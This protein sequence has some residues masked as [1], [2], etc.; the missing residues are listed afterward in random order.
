MKKLFGVLL[1]VFLLSAL[2][3]GAYAKETIVYYLWDD[4][5]YNNIVEVFN[6]SQDEIFVDAKVI[7]AG[8]YQTKL[9][10]LLA[11]GEYMDAYMNKDAV[12]IF[13]MVDN[14][15]A[16]PVDAFIEKH[17]FDA[18]PLMAYKDA[19]MIDGEIYA[20]PFRGEAWFTYY[21]KKV[22][23]AAGVPTPET[24]VEKGEWTWDKFAEVAN[25]LA[26]GDGMVYGGLM[27]VWTGCHYMPA[28]QRG[29]K[30][31]TADGAIDIDDSI[32]YSLKLRKDLE[33]ARTIIPMAELLATKTHYS[34]AFWEGNLGMLIIGAW[35]PGQMLS[36]RDEGN[37]KG[38]TWDDWAL[39][40]LPCNESE[41]RTTGTPTSNVLHADSEKKDAAF[42]FLA[43]M[44]GPEGSAVV[45]KNGFMPAS[46][47]PEVLE[48]LK[49]VL[50]DESSIKYFTEPKVNVTG[51]FNKYGARVGTF[52]SDLVEEY[53]A[54]EMTGDQ[55]MAKV[56]A[57]FEEIL[58]S[59]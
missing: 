8:D 7:P 12:H 1:V 48:A 44:S 54:S 47:S 21:N 22:F 59:E 53:L 24:Y 42:K 38:F 16:E 43:W 17:G 18:A 45:A 15:Y 3:M 9:M 14:G 41:Y 56:K 6:N 23:E 40:R 5:T 30:Y 36:A 10:T 27:Y 29:L 19:I 58:A 26:T 52:L 35:F 25:Q 28:D 4:P 55:V 49:T 39:T 13:Q 57:A 32:V 37:L 50:P 31:L 33:S 20:M 51:C 2:S 46:S 11:G 34:K